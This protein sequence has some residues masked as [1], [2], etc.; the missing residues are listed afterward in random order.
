MKKPFAKF[1]LKPIQQ[2]V[3]FSLFVS[4]SNSYAAQFE[5]AGLEVNFDSTFTL[6][7]SY[8]VENR[9]WGLIG[10]NNQS[11]IQ[12]QTQDNSYNAITNP[13]YTA[14]DIWSQPG[15][16]S[17][18]GDLGNLNYDPGEAFSRVISGTHELS[19]AA[20]DWGFFS[21]FM[22]FYDDAANDTA[23]S[24]PLTGEQY[25]ICRDEE[26]RKQICQDFRLLDAFVYGYFDLGDKPVSVRIGQQVVS[27]GESTLISHGIN[28]INPVDVARLK[29]PG[30]ELKEA[31]IPVGMVW[32]SVGLT[33]NLSFDAFYQYNWEKTVLPASGSYFSVNDFAGDGG[34]YN[35]VQIGFTQNP[36]INTDYLLSQLN[37]W[38][39]GYLQQNSSTIDG[40]M[41]Q[42]AATDDPAAQ[43]ALA[44][45]FYQ[46]TAPYYGFATK[47]ALMADDH[48]G[49]QYPSDSG[50][51]GAK[52]T[53]YAPELNDSEFGFYY[54]NYHSR[55]PL[56]SGRTSDFTVGSVYQD[57]KTLQS[58]RLNR[59]QLA[60]LS[61]FTQ[62]RLE[63][64][65]DIQLFGV[66]VNTS[67]SGTAIGAEFSYR[68]D[69]P[70]QVDDVELLLMGV[71]E[72][73]A[74]AGIRPDLAG[75]SQF[76]S[77]A[78]GD[79]A[80][81][82]ILRDSFQTQATV[83]HLFGPMLAADSLALVVE[84][85]ILHVQDMPEHDELR[86]NSPGTARPGQIQGDNVQGLQLGLSNGVE[87]TPFATATSWGYRSVAKLT[88]NN[89][90]SGINVSPKLVFSHDV[91]GIS[92]DPL[93]LFFEDRK[94]AALSLNFEYQ[95]RIQLDLSYN[96][97]WGGE[98][99]VNQF[100]DRDYVS[101]SVKYSI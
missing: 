78:P 81:G 56:I 51:W 27:W 98:G 42:M 71:P 63:Y 26:A 31:F 68:K 15:S 85:G 88:Y 20:D 11:N 48:N 50:Q 43:Q 66:S 65:E 12:W 89:L 34:Y 54:I 97:F 36:D 16:Y 40:L 94:S 32:A 38:V 49:N 21:R 83:T 62:A 10:K 2:A 75:I 9:D 91:N 29:A 52:L 41:A 25:D 84:A 55:R 87:M 80:R 82:Y 23:W 39:S 57:V 53:W 64:P 4:Q 61:A 96:S 28:S 77:V 95:N 99:Q 86:L 67:V 1:K 19:I 30:A 45:D 35:N 70:F 60:D 18:N 5:I 72:Q 79:T 59:H 33:D 17:A 101:V 47:V 46:I 22:Y 93:Y 73:L 44:S 76:A 7:T 13:I 24:N 69:E 74:N 3:L 37:G 6:G 100:A 8:R 58:T 90:F 14:D 92:P